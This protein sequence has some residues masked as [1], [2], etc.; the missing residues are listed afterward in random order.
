[1]K[2]TTAWAKRVAVAAA[3][4][5]ATAGLLLGA[6]GTASAANTQYAGLCVDSHLKVT[7]SLDFPN[8]SSY[9]VTPGTCYRI[10][11]KPGIPM[12]ISVFSYD[13][14]QHLTTAWR[15]FSASVSPCGRAWTSN[16]AVRAGFEQLHPSATALC[17]AR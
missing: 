9:V 16:G 10:Q 7:A 17:H 11:V 5:T 6:A 3:G 8:F 2:T 1:M 13:G 12:R 14:R 15:G 4:L